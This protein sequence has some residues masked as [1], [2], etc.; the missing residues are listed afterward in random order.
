VAKV[1]NQPE[2]LVFDARA[3]LVAV[4]LRA[5]SRLAFVD[6]HTLAVKRRV[7]L[8]AAPR[9]LALSP[10]GSAVVVPAESANAVVEVSPRRGVLTTT[11]VGDHPHDAVAA[12]DAVFVADEHSNQ[13]SVL[14]GGRD[15][16][17]LVAPQQPGGIAAVGDRY[18]ALVAVAARVLQV[19]DAHTLKPLGSTSAG[20][21]PTHVV[22]LGDDAYVADTEGGLI[23]EYRVGPQPRQIATVPAPGAPYGIAVDR[24]RH[25]LWVTRTASNRLAEYAIGV[26]RPPRQ[27][28]TYTT[29]RQPNSVEVDPRSG[30]VFV[31]GNAAG[32]I[33]RI[34]PRGEPR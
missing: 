30:D 6:P 7:S 20:I 25:R 18:V 5:P 27:V 32:V 26:G 17:T 2:G 10:S 19:Y 23:R 31:A 22:T 15:V 4:G 34:V 16:A 24:R 28:A 11:P 1:G 21:G 13:V 14:R 3:R 33:E 8:P 29:V 9:H 12:G